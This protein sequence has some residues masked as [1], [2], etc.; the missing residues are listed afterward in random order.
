MSKHAKMCSYI[1]RIK[2]MRK[3]NR[4]TFQHNH[5]MEWIICIQIIKNYHHNRNISHFYVPSSSYHFIS[6]SMN[7]FR[8]SGA[9]IIHGIYPWLFHMTSFTIH[10]QTITFVEDLFFFFF[11]QISP[12]KMLLCRWEKRKHIIEKRGRFEPFH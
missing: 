10:F 5:L 12:T 7:I 11:A 1:E 3:G 4:M 6:I 8:F 9:N 2:Q